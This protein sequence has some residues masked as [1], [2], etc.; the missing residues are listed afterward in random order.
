MKPTFLEL[1]RKYIA[2]Y[3]EA[4]NKFERKK[5]ATIRHY[6]N[7]YSLVCDFLF[8]L[9]TVKIYPHQFTDL[10]CTELFN[11][12]DGKE[13]SHNYSVRVV[14]ICISVLDFGAKNKIIQSNPSAYWSMPREAPQ[15]PIYL[16]AEKIKQIEDYKSLSSLKQKTADML[17]VQIHTGVGYGDFKEIKKTDIV[18]FKGKKYFI[19]PRHKNSNKQ[20]VPLSDIAENVF[21]KYNYDMQLLSNPVYNRW[22][23]VVAFELDINQKLKCRDGRTIFMMNKLNNEGYSMEAVSKMGGHKTVRTTEMYY[24]KVDI[25]LIHNEYLKLNPTG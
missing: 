9:Q 16:S 15:D 14:E 13:Y 22:L 4:S 21:L 7:K 3:R 25:N 12:L 23:K 6:N 10:L 2:Y 8:E 11:Y 19:K 17:V 1:F 24:A 5:P 18:N 20:V